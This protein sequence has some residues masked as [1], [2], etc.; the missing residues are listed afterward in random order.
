MFFLHSSMWNKHKHCQERTLKN[1]KCHNVSLHFLYSLKTQKSRVIFRFSVV[2]VY[3]VSRWCFYYS[4]YNKHLKT[5]LSSCAFVM[6]AHERKK[7]CERK[8]KQLFAGCMTMRYI[9]LC[10]NARL[11]PVMWQCCTWR[12]QISLFPQDVILLNSALRWWGGY[13]AYVGHVQASV[14]KWEVFT[15]S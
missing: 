2:Y 10:G 14:L 13:F 4:V 11:I 5:D 6:K 1:M 12:L 7:I 15:E 3:A 8:L 9:S